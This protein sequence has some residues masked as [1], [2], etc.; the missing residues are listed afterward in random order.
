MARDYMRPPSQMIAQRVPFTSGLVLCLAIVVFAGAFL[1]LEEIGW[2]K[3][4][5][6]DGVMYNIGLHKVRPENGE[7][8]TLYDLCLRARSGESALEHGSPWCQLHSAG[9]AVLNLLYLTCTA[10]IVTG[11]L[12]IASDTPA[13]GRSDGSRTTR[14]RPRMLGTIIAW[15]SAWL[16]LFTSLLTYALWAPPSLGGRPLQFAGTFVLVRHCVMLSTIIAA[17]IT[18]A[19]LDI[20]TESDIVGVVVS[21]TRS[22]IFEKALYAV[23]ICHLVLLGLTPVEGF[24]SDALICMVGI[25]A[26]HD[27]EENPRLLPKFGLLVVVSVVSTVIDLSGSH[28]WAGNTIVDDIGL[29]FK[30]LEVLLVAYAMPSSQ[31]VLPKNLR[32]RLRRKGTVR[33]GFS[34]VAAE[35][36]EDKEDDPN[37]WTALRVF[38]LMYDA[39]CVAFSLLDIFSD[40]LVLINWYNT[41]QMSYFWTGLVMFIFTSVWYTAFFVLLLLATSHSRTAPRRHSSRSTQDQQKHWLFDSVHVDRRYASLLFILLLPFGHTFPFIAFGL[42]RS[43]PPSRLREFFI[44]EIGGPIARLLADDEFFNGYFMVVLPYSPFLFETMCEAVPMTLIQLTAIVS[45]DTEDVA[46]V[47]LASIAISLSVIVMRGVTLAYSFSLHVTGFKALCITADVCLAFYTVSSL[48]ASPGVRDED[49]AGD[50]DSWGYQLWQTMPAMTP[51][52]VIWCLV[53]V[54]C[55]VYLA[56]GV[57]CSILV[58]ACRRR[59]VPLANQDSMAQRNRGGQRAPSVSF[60]DPVGTVLAVLDQTIVST[61]LVTFIVCPAF[62][63]AAMLTF[64]WFVIAIMVF[65]PEYGGSSRPWELR[66]VSDFTSSDLAAKA[67]VRLVTTDGIAQAALDGWYP[68]DH[69]AG[70]RAEE[71]LSAGHVARTTEARLEDLNQV[72]GIDYKWAKFIRLQRGQLREQLI[73][74]IEARLGPGPRLVLQLVLM[75]GGLLYAFAKLFSLL[76]PFLSFFLTPQTPNPI[77]QLTFVMLLGCIFGILLLRH[78][79]YRYVLL[80]TVYSGLLLRLPKRVDSRIRSIVRSRGQGEVLRSAEPLADDPPPSRRERPA[81]QDADR[82]LRSAK[83]ARAVEED[84]GVPQLDV[85]AMSHKSS[86]LSSI[87]GEEVKPLDTVAGRRL[88]VLTAYGERMLERVRLRALEQGKSTYDHLLRRS[89]TTSVDVGDESKARNGDDNHALYLP[90]E[91][92]VAL[93]LVTELDLVFRNMHEVDPGLWVRIAVENLCMCLFRLSATATRAHSGTSVELRSGIPQI[94]TE[95]FEP[96]WWRVTL[97]RPDDALAGLQQAGE[98]KTANPE[99]AVQGELHSP[100]VGAPVTADPARTP[101]AP[102]SVVDDPH[103]A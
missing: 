83:L 56:V 18:A 42:L 24:A 96:R 67:V 57:V 36:D 33:P 92:Q 91:R 97:E 64:T 90:T 50:A 7:P 22:S 70:A 25:Y 28:V 55:G 81:L 17:L 62:V 101:A 86:R 65:E 46:F 84:L 61:V 99:I 71:V 85:P 49:L 82:S 41:G 40:V 77:A 14:Q 35:E 26:L 68:T 76:F 75:V 1:P 21:V 88:M 63:F 27:S 52:G 73:E 69:R 45:T 34:V 54:I 87:V 60:S 19:L 79:Y 31:E 10:A 23:L 30:F 98:G 102:R 8:M 5:D 47:Q 58:F 4:T 12:S 11:A 93:A 37:A 80:C 51:L 72:L 74:P 89:S 100:H 59:I 43:A 3:G 6:V 48:F 32:D 39:G 20:W 9:S 29:F 15:V 44:Y 66:V 103:T 2:M 95:D 13:P 94:A 38:M 53:W 16:L 78:H